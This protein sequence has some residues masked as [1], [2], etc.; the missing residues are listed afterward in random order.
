[1]ASGLVQG[2]SVAAM[3]GRYSKFFE[4]VT[5]GSKSN[6]FAIPELEPVWVVGIFAARRLGFAKSIHTAFIFNIYNFFVN[7]SFGYDLL[8]IVVA[9]A[10]IY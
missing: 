4:V 3:L 7:F 6:R 5:L 2:F 1:M 8:L 9:K 10:F